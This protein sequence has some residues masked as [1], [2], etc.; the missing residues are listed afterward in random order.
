MELG[1]AVLWGFVCWK[2]RLYKLYKNISENGGN[3][4]N[5]R[6]IAIEEGTVQWIGCVV[7]ERQYCREL[8]ER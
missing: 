5:L 6:R 3:A 7:S 2:W 1:N 8:K 4:T